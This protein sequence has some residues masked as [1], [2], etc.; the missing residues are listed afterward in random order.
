M[1]TYVSYRVFFSFNSILS[2]SSI[3]NM[4]FREIKQGY[5]VYILDKDAL[6]VTQG[7][8]TGV[9]FP[10]IDTQSGGAKTVVDV[11]IE[12]NGTTATYTIPDGSAVAFSNSLV[13]S[14]DQYCL[15][16]EVEKMKADAESVLASIDRQKNIID[17]SE[18][19]IA[20]LNPAFKERRETERRF[21]K[22]ESHVQ[23]LGGKLD[24]LI[25]MMQHN[26]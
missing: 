1:S 14:T 2:L 25:Q 11:S 13:L 18:E 4:T 20:E 5:P 6:K 26:A 21:E 17:K 9:S 3:I 19:L 8:T 12:A 10:R 7:K 23:D 24:Q 16:A 15:I 22:I